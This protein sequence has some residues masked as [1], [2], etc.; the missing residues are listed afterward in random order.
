MTDLRGFTG[1]GKRRLLKFQKRQSRGRWNTS[2]SSLGELNDIESPGLRP[3]AT[4]SPTVTESEPNGDGVGAHLE[5]LRLFKR[6]S[7][8]CY[9][10]WRAF[11]RSSLQ[12]RRDDEFGL[13]G[14]KR[15]CSRKTH[16]I[17]TRQDQ[18][19]ELP[20]I[21]SRGRTSA[22]HESSSWLRARGRTSRPWKVVFHGLG[23]SSS[24][25]KKLHRRIET[26]AA[27]QTFFPRT[28]WLDLPGDYRDCG[29]ETRKVVDFFISLPENE[30]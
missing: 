3:L 27:P 15:L 18:A 24:S 21:N 30:P 14:S 23:R 25:P 20:E 12:L 17:A 1:E 6:D 5:R 11:E 29:P 13:D 19:R 4:L 9:Q 7:S 2:S 22:E 16:F 26:E 28:P 10:V 8:R